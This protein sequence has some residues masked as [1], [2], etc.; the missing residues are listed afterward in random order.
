LEKE[1]FPNDLG[2]AKADG[3]VYLSE[4]GSHK[5]NVPNIY[6]DLLQ[7][8]PADTANKLDSLYR[9]PKVPIGE[10]VR[11]LL[12]EFQ[13]YPV[14]LLLDNFE[15]F[16]DTETGNLV[17]SELKNLLENILLAPQHS[18]KIIITTRVPARD[19]A[20][21]EPSR[22]LPLHLDEGLK[23]PYAENIL[24]AMDSDGR[25]GFR[26]ASDEQLNRARELT[27]GYPRALESLFAIIS[28]DRYT[29]I[30]ELLAVELPDTVVESL[31]G[32][33]FSRLDANS[34][35]VMQTLAV[36]N[37]PVPPSAVDFLLQFHVPGINSSPILTRL[38]GMHFA[39]REA[40]RFYLHPTDRVYAFNRIP[41]EES[42]KPIG[43]GA[44]SRIWHQRA[45]LLR[46]ADYYAEAR[47]PQ[48]E[49]K[50]LEDLSAQLAEFDL[51]Y[52]AQ[53]YDAAGNVILE[54]CYEHIMTWGHSYL[55]I[56]LCLSLKDKIKSTQMR[57]YNLNV[58]GSA[59]VNIGKAKEALDYYQQGLAI[60][61]ISENRHLEGMTLGNLA[62][63]YI[64][65]GDISK[66]MESTEQA[67]I[68][69]REF[70]DEASEASSLGN[71]GLAYADLGDP[72]KAIEFYEQTLIIYTKV[73]K[74][75]LQA[76]T[77]ENYGDALLDLSDTERAIEYYQHAIQI[78]NAID[79]AQTQSYARWG[80]AQAKL[81]K[82]DLDDAYAITAEAQLYNVPQSNHDI[83][84]LQGIIALRK[85]DPVN[86][87]SSFQTSISHAD[88]ILA[89]TPEYYDALDA[90][91]LALSGLVLVEGKE[92]IAF[93]KETFRLAR[94]ITDAA[95]IVNR[96]LR[97]FD[98]LAKAD[99]EGI[100][101]EV[102]QVAG[103]KE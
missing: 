5:V 54:L 55:S 94:K 32:E 84:T 44:R 101:A 1:H 69:S 38:V 103:V 26:D 24:R 37:R 19:L 73:D 95:G 14:V 90:K 81:M 83:Y 15:L 91:G 13:K 102:R 36:Y 66:A 62:A 87:A 21:V 23:S 31:V 30:E 98:E 82:N 9:Q 10:K 12:E 16:V 68:I 77:F 41:G 96:V 33:A 80:L 78:A 43:K 97:L 56:E 76:V 48:N 93:A 52:A 65:L 57:V 39:R 18:I 89:D 29:S 11:F 74:Q 59:H 46:A 45:L 60:A 40:G 51:R 49:W 20:L 3:I 64:E 67:L 61:Q 63:V 75:R 99:T 25:A 85:N 100:L 27:L 79:F 7:L 28:V 42:N 22:N 50:K 47:K 70:K 71:L 2:E 6:A 88:K 53:D 34:Q 4:I 8:L 35:K 72:Q 92:Y 58:L 17:D 86:A